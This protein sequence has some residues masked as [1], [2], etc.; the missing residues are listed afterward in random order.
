MPS[1][2]RHLV[3]VAGLVLASPVAV[4]AACTSPAGNAG[5]VIFS[6]TAKTMQYCN[7]TNWV[8]TGKS[9]PAAT[10]SGCT[11][12]AGAAG[13]VIY[14]QPRGV[15]QFCNGQNWVDTSCAADRTPGGSG[16]GGKAAGTIQYSSTANELQFCDSTNWVAMGWGC[17]GSG[18]GSP[19]VNWA[20]ATEGQKLVASD[21]ASNDLF[22]NM[23]RIGDTLF[24]GANGDDNARGTDAGAVYVFT[25]SGGVWTEQAKLIASDG[26]AYQRFGVSIKADGNTLVVGATNDTGSNPLIGSVYVYTGSGSTWTLQAKLQASDKAV[27]DSFGSEVDISGES[28]IVAAPFHNNL[29]GAAY[30]FTRSGSTWT[31]QA[32]LVTAGI[33]DGDQIASDVAIEGDTALI[34]KITDTN[35]R[36]AAYVFTRSGSTWTERAKL[37][38]SDAVNGD[39]FGY[40]ARLSGGKAFIGAYLAH[41]YT[42]KAYVFSGS[43]SSW[44]QDAAFTGPDTAPGSIFGMDLSISDNTLLVGSANGAYVYTGSGSSWTFASKLFPAGNT[45]GDGTGGSVLLS[46]D[47]AFVYSTNS[48]KGAVHV[49]TP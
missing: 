18:G 31:Q 38:A 21:G 33:A 26:V 47:A 40:P 28:I 37:T 44:T 25:K 14:A 35:D 42:G 29:R 49:F 1:V 36:G 39:T 6:T 34:S 30:V 7:G 22:S 43:G 45:A 46:S 12:P 27:G 48:S 15:V 11:N 10:Q 32:K 8:N 17:T 20:T 2:I 3:L 4:W 5:A 16:C 23:A 19:S 13:A 24:V 41:T 9:E